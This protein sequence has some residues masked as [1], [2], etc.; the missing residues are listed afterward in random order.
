METDEDGMICHQC[1]AMLLGVPRLHA[2]LQSPNL[3][4]SVEGNGQGGVGTVAYHDACIL[5]PTCLPSLLNLIKT[6][7]RH[8]VGKMLMHVMLSIWLSPVTQQC[9]PDHVLQ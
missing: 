4:R 9:F 2:M 6:K 3:T 1:S 8:E 5:Q 7:P